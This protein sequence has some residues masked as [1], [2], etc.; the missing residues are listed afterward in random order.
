M[1]IGSMNA[2]REATIRLI[3]YGAQGQAQEIEAIIDPGCTG[4]KIALQNAD[5]NAVLALAFVALVSQASR[6]AHA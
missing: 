4:F 5:S 6:T 3:V 2:P 1:I